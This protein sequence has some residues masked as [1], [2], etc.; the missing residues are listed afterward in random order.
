MRNYINENQIAQVFGNKAWDM[1]QN[2]TVECVKFNDID[3]MWEYTSAIR[4]QATE[5]FEDS[6]GHYCYLI[7]WYFLTQ[8]EHEKHVEGIDI[9]WEVAEYMME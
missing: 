6:H 9:N 1:I 4:I 3:E 7:A 5:D 8:E 2:E